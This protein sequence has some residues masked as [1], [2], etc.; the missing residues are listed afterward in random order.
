MPSDPRISVVMPTLDRPDTLTQALEA[1]AQQ[2][3][4]ADRFELV[5]A[6]DARNEATPELP[7]LPFAVQRVKGSR[8]G[9]SAARNAGWR[10]A[11]ASLVLF[12]GDDIIA[13]PQLL[14]EHF[15]WHEREPGDGVGV[16][17]SVDWARSL[18]RDAFMTWLDA[19]IQFDYGSIRGTEAGAG[20]FYTANVSLKRAMLER[21]GG[22]D[23]ERFPFL[24]ED[25]DLGV[26]LFEHG[27]RLL[28]NRAAA[29]E[30]LHQPRIEEWRVRMRLVAAA[31]RRRGGW[32]SLGTPD[33]PQRFAGAVARPPA[34]RRGGAPPRAGAPAFPFFF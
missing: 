34:R 33:F 11:G 1:L 26:R 14:A 29:A 9:A 4:G 18:R 31:G 2:T 20:H 22:F 10:A 32:H 21:V 5:L 24:Y 6:E 12:I 15:A 28:Y 23:E 30:H 19:G 7:S 17:G 13:S 27:F 8:P 25:I 3:L 16:L